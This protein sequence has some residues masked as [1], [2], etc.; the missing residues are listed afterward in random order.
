MVLTGACRRRDVRTTVI[1]VP[2]LTDARAAQIALNAIGIEL[3]RTDA[4]FTV[5]LKDHTMQHFSSSMV[6]YPPVQSNILAALHEVGLQ[7]QILHAKPAPIDAWR[8]RHAIT[9]RLPELQNNRIANIAVGAVN[10]AMAGKDPDGVRADPAA[11]TVT[12]A[13]DTMVLR[14]KNLEHAIANAGLRTRA[15]PAQLEFP[16]ALPHGWTQQ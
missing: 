8:D 6:G 10:R 16:D 12:I 7:A 14:S 11:H 15:I 13:Y 4:N 2:D 5:D 1:E 9:L 3:T